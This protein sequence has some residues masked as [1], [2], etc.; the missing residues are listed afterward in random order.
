DPDRAPV[1]C[2]EPTAYAHSGPEAA[3]AAMTALWH[4]VPQQVDV[5]MQEVVLIANMANPARFPQ[6]GFR[7]KRLGANIGRTREIWPTTDGFVSFGLRGGKARVPTLEL[8][9]KL[10]GL[11]PRDWSQFAP[12]TAS[13]DDHDDAENT[14]VGR[15]AH[16]R[17]RLRGGRADRDALLRRARRD[18]VAY[19]IEGASRL[20]AGVLARPRQPARPRRLADVRRT[21]RRQAQPGV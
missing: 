4:G 2:T 9:A 12:N 11:A 15:L 21:Q 19:R 3:F 16:P 10:A 18:G 1:R 13:D 6:T 20:L 17:V 8:I 5:S 7:G 14:R